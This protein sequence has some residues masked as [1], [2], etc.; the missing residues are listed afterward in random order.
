MTAPRLWRKET[1]D[2]QALARQLYDRTVE[3]LGID[4]EDAE[5]SWHDD[6]TRHFWLDSAWELLEWMGVVPPQ[7]VVVLSHEWKV[8]RL[9]A[10][11]IHDFKLDEET[12]VVYCGKCD[13]WSPGVKP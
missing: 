12:D 3:V 6:V 9:C 1:P 4:E 13:Y 10:D 8:P 5:L 11:A 2:H 7:D